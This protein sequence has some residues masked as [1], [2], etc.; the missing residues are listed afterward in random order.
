MRDLQLGNATI[1]NPP[2]RLGLIEVN[3]DPGA[4]HKNVA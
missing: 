2:V 4:L 3:I 1:M